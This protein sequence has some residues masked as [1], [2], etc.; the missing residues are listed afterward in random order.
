MNVLRLNRVAMLAIGRHKLRTFLSILGVAIGVGAVVSMVAVGEGATRRVQAAIASLGSNLLWVEEGSVNSRG[1]HTGSYGTRTLVIGDA[2][3]I[4]SQVYLVTNVSPQVDTNVQVIYGDKNWRSTVRG[5]SPEYLAIRQWPVVMGGPFTD[6]EVRSS[7]N[8]CILGQTVVQRLFDPG[9]DPVGKMIRV[10]N[11][12]CLVI[13]VLA[14]KGAAA[15]G[16]DQDDTF[17]MPYTTV[18]RKI[19]G[20]KWLDDILCSATSED[21]LDE[22]EQMIAG[23]LRERHHILPGAPDDFNFRHPKE[24]AEAVAQ[25]KEIMKILL[26]S[27]ASIS[28]LVGGIGIMNI[29]LVSVTERTHEIGLRMSVGARG[30]DIQQQFLWEAVMLSLTG[31]LAGIA[32]GAVAADVLTNTLQWPVHVSLEAILLAFGFS[33]AVGMFFGLYPAYKASRLDPIDALRFEV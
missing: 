3:A 27:I 32:L 18:M 12:P 10:K 21:V 8:V 19:M 6:E 29:M 23:L 7:A 11:L 14:A 5:E 2:E 15:T 28:L 22:A 1:V 30:V 25:S 20:Q 16:G 13:G 31:G 33:A 9:E 26:A 17:I 4:K 24:I